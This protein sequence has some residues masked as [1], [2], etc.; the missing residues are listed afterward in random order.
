MSGQ[1][2]TLSQAENLLE[3]VG[4]QYMQ[5]DGVVGVG[6][7]IRHKRLQFVIALD[8]AINID[9]KQFPKTVGDTPSHELD[10]FL[11]ESEFQALCCCEE[12]CD[13]QLLAQWDSLSEKCGY[14]DDYLW[15]KLFRFVKSP[16]GIVAAVFFLLF[17]GTTAYLLS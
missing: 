1:D 10:V 6:V 13:P 17:G 9:R 8:P 16:F 14:K 11:E 7:A 2:I 12:S 5:I 3:S 4:Q 15:A